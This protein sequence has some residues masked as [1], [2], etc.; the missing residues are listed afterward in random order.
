MVRSRCQNCSF[1]DSLCSKFFSCFFHV[2]VFRCTKR[3]FKTC[4]CW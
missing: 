1:C 2:F 3:R 4:E